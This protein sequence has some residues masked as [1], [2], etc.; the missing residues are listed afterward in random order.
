MEKQFSAM[1]LTRALTGLMGELS[2]AHA[3]TRTC[4]DRLL[5]S[6]QGPACV[7]TNADKPP[8]HSL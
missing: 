4:K 8:K 1:L 7:Y 6:S 5:K 3:T 2:C